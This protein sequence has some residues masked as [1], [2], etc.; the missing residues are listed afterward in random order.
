[1]VRLCTSGNDATRQLRSNDTSSN[2]FSRGPTWRDNSVM[3]LTKANTRIAGHTSFGSSGFNV[4]RR[5]EERNKGTAVTTDNRFSM[6][7]NTHPV[8]FERQLANSLSEYSV[9]K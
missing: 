1:M 6:L 5:M 3:R 9:L 7:E 8:F 2:G 4:R